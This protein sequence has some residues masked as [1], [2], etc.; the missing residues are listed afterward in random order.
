MYF[1]YFYCLPA[2]PTIY[3]ILSTYFYCSCSYIFLSHIY[4]SIPFF[5]LYLSLKILSSLQLQTPVCFYLHT[6]FVNI[7]TSIIKSSSTF[8]EV[9]TVSIYKIRSIASSLCVCAFF[10][11]TILTFYFAYIIY[12]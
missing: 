10:V 11:Q 5:H 1:R 6:F 4:F 2:V 9:F 12:Y 7:L 3:S 8:L